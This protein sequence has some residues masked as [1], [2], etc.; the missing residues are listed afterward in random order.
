MLRQCRCSSAE[1]VPQA[2]MPA[3][4]ITTSTEPCASCTSSANAFTASTSVMSSDLAYATLPPAAVIVEMVSSRG[5]MS[6]RITRAPRSAAT[7]AV[8]RPMPLAAPVTSTS[9]PLMSVIPA[10]Y[11][12]FVQLGSRIKVLLRM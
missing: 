1:T 10:Y 9:L 6:V 12:Q 2:E 8:A 4:F 3:T 5:E 11:W 7:S